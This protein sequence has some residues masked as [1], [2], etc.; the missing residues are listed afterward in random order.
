MN[1]LE[2]LRQPW[3]WSIS[4]LLIGLSVPILLI[5]GNKTFWISSSLRHVCAKYDRKILAKFKTRKSIFM[6]TKVD[7][8]TQL[9]KEIRRI[10]RFNGCVLIND[11]FN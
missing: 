10:I 5:L 6:I 11:N 3:H 7:I 8:R 1:I 4:G 2:T 9:T